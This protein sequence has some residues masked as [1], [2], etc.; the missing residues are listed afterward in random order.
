MVQDEKQKTA[1][2]TYSR[3]TLK[4]F[5]WFSKWTPAALM[6]LHAS[7]IWAYGHADI[8]PPSHDTHG[9]C[10]IYAYLAA[11][12]LP[13][14]I[15]PASRFFF[16]CRLYRVPFFYFFGVNAIHITYR[17]WHT[18]ADMVM[19]HYCLMVLTAMVYI[20]AFAS[21]FCRQTKAGQRIFS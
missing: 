18:A 20:H 17:S 2:R 11:Y 21:W 4:F 9:L 15:A 6:A 1:G 8:R 16:L 13:L 14:V 5:R 19:A 12:V 3:R 7:G 10:C